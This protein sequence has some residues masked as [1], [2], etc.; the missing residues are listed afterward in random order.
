MID[1]SWFQFNYLHQ[2]QQHML[3]AIVVQKAHYFPIEQEKL[4]KLHTHYPIHQL[5]YS[6]NSKHNHHVA[7]FMHLEALIKKNSQEQK[8][9]K[10]LSS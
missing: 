4:I 10:H 3:L 9:N 1:Y 7:L 2:M 8:D 6:I 5:V